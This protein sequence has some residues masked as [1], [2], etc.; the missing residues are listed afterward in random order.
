MNRLRAYSS[1][2]HLRACHL[3]VWSEHVL[4]HFS[5]CVRPEVE[6]RGTAAGDEVLACRVSAPTRLC[7][8]Q[9]YAHIYARTRTYSRGI[10]LRS[11]P[12][13]TRTTH[14]GSC[15]LGDSNVTTSKRR[16]GRQRKQAKKL[17]E[18]AGKS[19][20]DSGI[21]N[22]PHPGDN[23]ASK[24]KRRNKRQRT[25]SKKMKAAADKLNGDS[26]TSDSPHSA[27]FDANAEF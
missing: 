24:R 21:S 8:A 17:K 3:C 1:R 14:S 6:A 7:Y 20:G 19:N 4:R 22:S 12:S 9:A 2:M 15:E 10:E 11:R 26:D 13:C 27:P 5:G 16:C 23:N 18:A 25:Q